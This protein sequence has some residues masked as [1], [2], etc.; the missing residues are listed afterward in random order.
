MPISGELYLVCRKNTGYCDNLDCGANGECITYDSGYH[1]KCRCDSG[2]GGDTCQLNMDDCA[3]QP[4]NNAA[5]C[6]DGLDAF[7]CSCH[8]TGTGG[9]FQTV[10]L[11]NYLQSCKCF[12]IFP[13][14]TGL[15][16]ET[17]NR[18]LE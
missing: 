10:T 1:V 7:T 17:I 5:V 6:E 13:K 2:Y 9:M 12:I 15:S 16:I 14:L 11:V 4:C 8:V 3:Y 18:G